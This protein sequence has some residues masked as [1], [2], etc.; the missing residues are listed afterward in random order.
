MNKAAPAPLLVEAFLAGGAMIT[1]L[2]RQ[3]E[4]RKR[5]VDVLNSPEE[6][7]E[8]E[9]A[10]LSLRHGYEPLHLPTISIEKRS[11]LVAVPRET[12]EQNHRRAVLT[13]MIGHARTVQKDVTLILPPYAIDGIAHVAPGIGK[14]RPHADI[15]RHFFPITDAI[16]TI[17][18][19]GRR[20]MPVILVNREA[21]VG[22]SLRVSPAAASA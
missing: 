5:L 12:S 10:S 11:I 22:M 16:V 13:N 1:G 9:Q 6:V 14:L 15:F 18:E 20:P 19:E 4:E 8:I 21:I 7:I 17:P 3:V 2:C